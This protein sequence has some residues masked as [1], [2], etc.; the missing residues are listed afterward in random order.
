[1]MKAAIEYLKETKVL[2]TTIVSLV[3]S[4]I[5]AYNG[6]LN[7][8]KDISTNTKLI[9]IS[10]MQMLSP[11]VRQMEKNPCTVTDREW[12]EYEMNYSNLFDL[13]VKYKKISPHA[14]NIMTRLEKD[15]ESCTR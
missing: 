7:I 2:V 5:I 9:E 3:S 1:M 14:F 13:K 11:I 4:V 10:Q 6:Y 15:K 8:K 12:E